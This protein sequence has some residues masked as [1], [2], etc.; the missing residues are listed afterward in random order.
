MG[1]GVSLSLSRDGVHGERIF[2]LFS[3]LISDPFPRD[4]G[5]YVVFVSLSRE[6]VSLCERNSSGTRSSSSQ[7]WVTPYLSQKEKFDSGCIL[8][9]RGVARDGTT[10]TQEE[11]CRGSKDLY[12]GST[13][14]KNPDIVADFG[15]AATDAVSGGAGAV[16][17][18]PHG[19]ASSESLCSRSENFDAAGAGSE[20]AGTFN[21][22][23]I[24]DAAGAVLDVD[25]ITI[26][27]IEEVADEDRS[28][29]GVFAF[30][31]IRSV[32]GYGKGPTD[33]VAGSAGIFGVPKVACGYAIG[34]GRPVSYCLGRCVVEMVL[35]ISRT[36]FAAPT[37]RS[38]GM[39][40]SLVEGGFLSPV[41]KKQK[42]WIPDLGFH[43]APTPNGFLVLDF[44]PLRPCLGSTML[45]FGLVD[46]SIAIATDHTGPGAV[47]IAS[48]ADAISVSA[49]S[50]KDA[51]VN[52]FNGD[53][54]AISDGQRNVTL[55]SVL[56]RFR[57]DSGLVELVL[58]PIPADMATAAFPYL[59]RSGQ[60]G[61]DGHLGAIKLGCRV[62]QFTQGIAIIYGSI[63]DRKSFFRE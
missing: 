62:G 16:A 24:S 46:D 25:A 37:R 50:V 53:L 59:P 49:G 63:N 18:Y 23:A 12:A 22:T 31:P 26:S 9:H 17:S 35:Q 10:H 21:A 33:K 11:V 1:A 36:D 28:E 30:Q 20:V 52:A 61:C 32:S 6:F 42:T 48:N 58:P 56:D 14:T 51:A 38:L 29:H 41:F 43:S 34:E 55:R 27:D 54:G 2:S 13:E 44:Q 4:H 40:F 7:K 47:G 5:F 8:K 60:L 45:G 19:Y 15:S 57:L 39:F 3:S